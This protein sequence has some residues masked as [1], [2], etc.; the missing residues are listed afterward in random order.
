ADR[1]AGHYGNFSRFELRFRWGPSRPPPYRTM[2]YRLQPFQS[3]QEGRELVARG[4][5]GR[6]ARVLGAINMDEGVARGAGAVADRDGRS[7]PQFLQD[8]RGWRVAVVPAAN[9]A[10]GLFIEFFAHFLDLHFSSPK[11][12]RLKWM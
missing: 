2:H 9:G 11:S 4:L 8:G 10:Q 12:L 7:D 6:D 5:P 1:H 3:A